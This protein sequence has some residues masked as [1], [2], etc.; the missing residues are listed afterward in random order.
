MLMVV[1]GGSQAESVSR[2]LVKEACLFKAL[3]TWL[4]SRAANLDFFY[5]SLTPTLDFHYLG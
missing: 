2:G 5:S 3:I 4:I 1:D